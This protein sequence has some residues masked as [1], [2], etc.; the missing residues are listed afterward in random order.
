MER[1]SGNSPFA[2]QQ[3]PKKTACDIAMDKK[4]QEYVKAKKIDEW[5]GGEKNEWECVDGKVQLINRPMEDSTTY[6][7]K[8][9][10]NK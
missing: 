9:I 6:D 3:E 7:V 4:K 1:Y 5:E 2:Q 8:K 10:N